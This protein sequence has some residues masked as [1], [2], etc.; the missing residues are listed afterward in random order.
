MAG[1]K[2]RSR[3]DDPPDRIDR[4]PAR[5]APS[6]RT[7]SGL[8]SPF[9]LKS[10]P[11]PA[12]SHISTQAI[13]NEG[14]IGS[15]FP[16]PDGAVLASNKVGVPTTRPHEFGG[17]L[18]KQFSRI[19]AA[20]DFSKPARGAFEYALAL[21]QEHGAELVVVHAVPLN[22]AFAWDAP[23]RFALMAKLRLRARQAGVPFTDRVQQGDPAEII[24]LHA[25]SLRPDVI[26][27]GT[28]QRRGIERLGAGSVAERIAAKATAP[29]LLIPPRRRSGTIRPFSHVAVAL[30]LSTGSDRAIE[31]ALALANEPGDRITLLHVVPGFAPGVPP[32]LYRYGI[33]EY[34]DELRRDGRRRLQQVL[35]TKWDTHAA[36]DARV[37][38]GDTTTEIS[39]VVDGIG[40]DLLVVGASTRGFVSRALHG[41]TAAQLLRVTDVPML[42][43][44]DVGTERA[45]HDSSL[46]QVAA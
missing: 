28:H 27:A 30:D 46:R 18:L 6:L 40:A 38:V 44:P 32:H 8:K 43:V 14:I 10:T 23:E 5:I 21:S 12:N 9:K 36:I 22:Q 19:L 7:I 42:A 16:A 35:S 11:P 45:H 25:R 20:V 26:V 29:V 1:M 4:A 31:Q 3:R 15:A 17:N 41:T 33:A 34:Q 37:L 13:A 24:L 39:R 2:S